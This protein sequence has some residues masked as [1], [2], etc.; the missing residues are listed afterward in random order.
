MCVNPEYIT[1][2]HR[3][4]IIR[5]AMSTEDNI[6]KYLHGMTW[7]ETTVPPALNSHIPDSGVTYLSHLYY[8]AV[9][10]PWSSPRPR[11]LEFFS[12]Q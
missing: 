2:Q 12:L 1:G 9:S 8:F 5:D 7:D 11:G 6:F 3:R 10:P 4:E